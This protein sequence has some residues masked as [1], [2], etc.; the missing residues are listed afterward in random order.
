MIQKN[1]SNFAVWISLF[2]SAST[3]VCCALPALFVT[4]GFGAI[5]AGL[6]A[7]LP[8][9]I[10][11]SEHKTLVFSGAAIIILLTGILREKSK[12]ITCPL[13]PQKREICLRLRKTSDWV[14]RT[15]LILYGVGFFFAF[16]APYLVR[17]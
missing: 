1:K 7:N 15:S 14:Y 11:L 8:G 10:W 6:V 9:L 13:D 4:L 16:L 12:E 3:L 17:S 2:A 5:V